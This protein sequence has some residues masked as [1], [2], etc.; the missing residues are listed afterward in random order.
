[1]NTNTNANGYMYD[2]CNMGGV[3]PSREAAD[4][5]LF[6]LKAGKAYP[7][8]TSEPGY[9]QRLEDI[10]AGRPVNPEYFRRASSSVSSMQLST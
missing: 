4:S 2:E 10:I 1:M 9:E 5:L 6:D 7:H 3:P 8:P